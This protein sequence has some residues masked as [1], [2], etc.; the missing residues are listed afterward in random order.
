MSFCLFLYLK[1]FFL[2]KTCIFDNVNFFQSFY[3]H[4]P[5]NIYT[6]S[7]A[8]I[9]MAQHKGTG[10]FVL[11]VLKDVHPILTRVPGKGIVSQNIYVLKHSLRTW[12]PGKFQMHTSVRVIVV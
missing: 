10:S 5:Y 12:L 4:N 3:Q 1:L 2:F 11:Y 7:G 9:S 6:S 8:E